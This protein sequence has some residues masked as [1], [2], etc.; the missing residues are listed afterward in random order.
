MF[1]YSF[2]F[3]ALFERVSR[4]LELFSALNQALFDPFF[5]LFGVQKSGHT[6]LRESQKIRL[7]AMKLSELNL[8]SFALLTSLRTIS[9]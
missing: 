9:K 7:N 1:F 2:W 3:L 5:A 4:A 8:F 6:G